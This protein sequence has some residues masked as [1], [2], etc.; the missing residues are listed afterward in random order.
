[1]NEYVFLM[2]LNTHIII[3][4]F[5]LLFDELLIHN[6]G[7]IPYVFPSTN[8]VVQVV[9]DGTTRWHSNGRPARVEGAWLQE[10]SQT[11]Q[12]AH[13][14]QGKSVEGKSA[15][16]SCLAIICLHTCSPSLSLNRLVIKA[17]LM[18]SPS[19]VHNPLSG[20]KNYVDN[21]AT[22]FLN[23][24]LSMPVIC[25]ASALFFPLQSVMLLCQLFL[26]LSCLP[27]LPRMIPLA[28]QC[29]QYLT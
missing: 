3:C 29:I 22:I 2:N 13:I 19:S 5:L 15:M 9:G 20:C 12:C 25:R 21:P 6:V 14:H 11:A 24:R 10:G 7:L 16:F 28:K 1:M 8:R 4:M 27:T 17:L 18:M 23:L 26:G